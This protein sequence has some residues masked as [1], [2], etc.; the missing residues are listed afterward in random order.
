[1]EGRRRGVVVVFGI[2]IVEYAWKRDLRIWRLL[3]E[4]GDSSPHSK[5]F[6]R[7]SQFGCRGIVKVD[8]ATVSDENK[9]DTSDR[10]DVGSRLPVGHV[11]SCEHG[12]E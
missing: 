11:V 1:M 12:L 3:K 7:I 8:V 6:V 2:P 4:S 9:L 5:S 10:C